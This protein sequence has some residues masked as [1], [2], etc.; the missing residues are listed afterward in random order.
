M[1]EVDKRVRTYLVLTGGFS[2]A[3]AVIALAMYHRD[4]LQKTEKEVITKIM[5][6]PENDKQWMLSHHDRPACLIL[7]HL[8]YRITEAGGEPVTKGTRFGRK[9]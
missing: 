3:N 6:D 7:D 8:N 1:E 9:I 2:R 4:E 5:L